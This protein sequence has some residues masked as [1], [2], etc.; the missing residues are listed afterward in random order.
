MPTYGSVALFMRS[1]PC[2]CASI[3]V[4]HVGLTPFLIFQACARPGNLCKSVRGGQRATPWTTRS[5][6]LMVRA[7]TAF[8]QGMQVGL[9]RGHLVCLLTTECN[10]LREGGWF[11]VLPYGTAMKWQILATLDR[12]P[13]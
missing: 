5:G 12:A 11:I 13:A 2:T 4:W 7:S 6:A 3:P 9:G 1:I 10:V 8:K